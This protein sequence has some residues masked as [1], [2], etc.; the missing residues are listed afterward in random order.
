MVLTLRQWHSRPVSGRHLIE[1]TKFPPDR[2]FPDEAQETLRHAGEH[3]FEAC[4]PEGSHISTSDKSSMGE[5][6]PDCDRSTRCPGLE[7]VETRRAGGR[8]PSGLLSHP[9]DRGVTRIP[10]PGLSSPPS[11]R[12]QELRKWR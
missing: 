11:R 9:S 8:L 10:L 1:A 2:Y 7:S 12:R 5:T 6:T 3:G 4:T